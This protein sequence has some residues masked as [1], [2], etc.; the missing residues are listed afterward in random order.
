MLTVSRIQALA[1]RGKGVSLAPQSEVA[2]SCLTLWDP[3]DCSLPGSS[4]HGVFQA[5]ILEWVAFP[6]LRRLSNGRWHRW[7]QASWW[8]T[9]KNLLQCRRWR[10]NP[11]RRNWQP[12]PVFLPGEIHGQRSL[13]GYS[14]WDCTGLDTTEATNIHTDDHRTHTS[15]ALRHRD[16]DVN[17]FVARK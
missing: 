12:T 8:Q 16:S 15:V 11:W 2:Q 5:G 4:V 17:K 9:I 3:M 14:P 1:P 10:F 13:L 6:S 7:S